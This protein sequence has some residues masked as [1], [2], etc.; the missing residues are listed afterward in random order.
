MRDFV[1]RLVITALALWVAIQLV[2]GIAF[3]GPPLALLGVALV[4][5][6]VNAVLKPLLTILTCP[7]IL[8]TLGLFT[9]VLNAI[10]LLATAR[11]SQ[12]L[13]LGFAVDGFWPAF[14]GGLLI[15]ISSTVL[16]ALTSDRQHAEQFR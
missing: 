16:V 14:W 6:V 2:D 9:L 11:L 12:A 10:L 13:G 7:L 1:V 4:F 8:L 15:G 5:G 3:T